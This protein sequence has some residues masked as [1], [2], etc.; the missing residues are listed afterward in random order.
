MTPRPVYVDFHFVLDDAIAT[1]GSLDAARQYAWLFEL[2]TA[3]GGQCPALLPNAD[4]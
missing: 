2:A 4:Y 1:C 3:A